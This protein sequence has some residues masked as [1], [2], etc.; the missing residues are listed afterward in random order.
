MANRITSAGTI[1]QDGADQHP[2]RI[3]KSVTKPAAIS[4]IVAAVVVIG[5]AAALL[6]VRVTTPIAGQA[7]PAAGAVQ[8]TTKPNDPLQPKSTGGPQ[9][10]GWTPI[11]ISNGAALDTDKA[12]DVPQGW[13]PIGGGLATF[14]DHAEV[15]LAAPAIYKQG[16]CPDNP[17]SW[18]A[19][20]GV[21]VLPNKGNIEVGAAAAAQN[22]ANVVFTTKDRVQPETKI[23]D[24]QPV[25]VY[26]NK[27]GVVVTAKLTVPVT[28]KDTC[29]AASVTVAV[30]M[31]EANKE[32]DADNVSII[33]MGDQNVP[34]AT[35][36]QD[37]SRIV[38]SLH[39]IS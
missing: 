17:K 2:R 21:A 39:L 20:A 29:A 9:V 18:R 27:K 30:M 11:P 31:L 37:L 19:M 1:W 22:I 33:A 16:Y 7:L 26:R 32:G 38:T 3:E 10:A 8:T 5:V 12:Y 15:S 6:F 14:G 28:E 24:P 23:S 4:T 25:T 35:P 13:S 36:E 34:E